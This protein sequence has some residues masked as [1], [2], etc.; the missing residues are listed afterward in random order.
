MSTFIYRYISEA[1]K[2][3]NILECK[4]MYEA[5][6]PENPPQ[7][8]AL[9]ATSYAAGNGN[10]ELLQYFHSI[11]FTWDSYAC[12]GAAENGHL[13]CLQYLHSN[14]CPWDGSTTLYSAMGGHLECLMYAHSNGCSLY[15]NDT[16]EAC[17][18]HGH[19]ACL[20]YLHNSG[21]NLNDNLPFIAASGGNIECL[22]YLHQNGCKLSE[23]V[24]TASLKVG[25]IECF[26]YVYEKNGCVLTNT[27][28]LNT[29]KYGRSWAFSYI[30][31][32]CKNPQECFDLIRTHKLNH[33]ILSGI[34]IDDPI[35]RRCFPLDLSSQP[36]FQQMIDNKKHDIHKRQ[37]ECRNTLIDKVETD[38]IRYCI[39]G[40]I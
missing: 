32:N 26:T 18:R 15:A 33:S 36:A 30:V 8:S 22:K 27:A 29:I 24:Y 4:R 11:G 5:G 1:A 31:S 38:V 19:L 2:A 40:Y 34:D 20:Q 28:I 9:K 6:L 23:S 7:P 12:E 25:N 39:Y 35:W 10:L 17:V 13:D 37:E 3:N 16:L 14:G 21:C